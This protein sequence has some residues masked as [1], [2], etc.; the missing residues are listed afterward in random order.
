MRIERPVVVEFMSYEAN[1]IIETIIMLQRIAE[2]SKVFSSSYGDDL[3]YCADT[4]VGLLSTTENGKEEL[5]NRNLL[6]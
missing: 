6:D 3:R 2:D 5:R 1:H 4:L